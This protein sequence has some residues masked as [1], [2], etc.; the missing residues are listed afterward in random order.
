ML[1]SLKFKEFE[2]FKTSNKI[3]WLPEIQCLSSCIL[4]SQV[5]RVNLYTQFDGVV[6]SFELSATYKFDPNI[7][8]IASVRTNLH[9]Y[10]KNER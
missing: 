1:Q 3:V 5:Y 10:G 7:F 2:N 6:F 8:K 4:Y 9:N